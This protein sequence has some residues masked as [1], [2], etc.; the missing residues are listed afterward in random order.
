[1][2]K[3]PI[4]AIADAAMA[5]PSTPKICTETRR[6]TPFS[7]DQ[8]PSTCGL[9][10]KLWKLSAQKIRQIFSI[11]GKN[12]RIPEMCGCKLALNITGKLGF[13]LEATKIS[14]KPC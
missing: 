8:L 3:C 12:W 11:L 7:T 9:F 14:I 10:T 4:A 6:T 5:S 2:A 13:W 1:M